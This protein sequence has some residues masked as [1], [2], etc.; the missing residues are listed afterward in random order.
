M[1]SLDLQVLQASY[2]FTLGQNGE[3]LGLTAGDSGYESTGIILDDYSQKIF[4]LGL[5]I[6]NNLCALRPE[7]TVECA[8]GANTNGS[9]FLQLEQGDQVISVELSDKQFAQLITGKVVIGQLIT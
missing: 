1:S 5:K 8:L 9:Y 6:E 4:N 2:D 3:V 7:A